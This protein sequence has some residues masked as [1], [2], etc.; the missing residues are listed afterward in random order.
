MLIGASDVI[1]RQTRR[2]FRYQPGK[3]QLILATFVMDS[4]NAACTQ[5][6]GYFDAQNGIFFE[7]AGT[8]YNLVRRSFTG[9]TA[10]DLQVP[11]ADWNIDSFDGNGPSGISLNFTK[12]QILLIDMEWLGVGRVRCGF[13]VDGIPY[14]A[15]EFLHANFVSSV[16]MTTPNLPIR[17]EIRGTAGLATGKTLHAICSSVI[18]EGGF[19]IASG[20]QFSADNEIVTRSVTNGA[21]VPLIAVRPKLTYGGIANRGRIIM[22]SYSVYSAS[23][24]IHYDL[25][26]GATVSGGSWVSVNDDS[27]VEYNVTGTSVSGGIDVD[28]NYLPSSVQSRG[29]A[30]NQNTADYPAFLDISGAHP[31]TPYSDIWVIEAKSLGNNTDCAAALQWRELR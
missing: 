19:Q 29:I 6:V 24:S 3:S 23:V 16:Y 15:H 27:I 9:G 28:G 25:V 10:S 18:S 26:F 21:Y 11:R 14:Y 2:Y 20:L 22:E 5:R 1:I 31:T 30:N 7:N 12:A 17:Y 13:V 4:P 8:D